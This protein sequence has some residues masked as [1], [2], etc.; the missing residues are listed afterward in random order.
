VRT[1]SQGQLIDTKLLKHFIK[2]FAETKPLISEFEKANKK[3][4][5]AKRRLKTVEIK[6]TF[7]FDIVAPYSNDNFL[8]NAAKRLFKSTGFKKV[9][10]FKSERLKPKREDLQLWTDTELF[11]IE[12][13]GLS[14][15]HPPKSALIQ[16]LPYIRENELHIKD[17]NIYGFTVINHDNKNRPQD[18]QR[19][20]K[21]A[22]K[23]R[24][25]V[26]CGYG[27]ISTMDLLIG[28]TYL[29]QGKIDFETFKNTLKNKGL[30]TYEGKGGSTLN[31]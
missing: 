24:D 20:F 26:N 27:F 10:H 30:I 3:L 14:T 31:K 19:N 1:N 6:Y 11:V 17:R 4:R 15:P 5:T 13:K 29:K 8:A 9:V 12:I 23:E 18:R 2:D 25:A 16:V 28:F 7:L 21:D 22:E